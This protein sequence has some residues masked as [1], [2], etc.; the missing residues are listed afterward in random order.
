M[1]T[2][3]RFSQVPY[4]GPPGS[5]ELVLVRHGASADAVEGEDFE[6]LDGHGD[7]PLSDIGREQAE[8]VGAR[9]ARQSFDALY[10][11]NLRRTVET[12]APL[13][14]LSGLVPVVEAD[15][16]EVRLGEWEGGLFRQKVADGD[17]VAVRM[18]TEERWDV[19]PGAETA[20]GF[21]GRIRRAIE[22]V[23]ASHPGQRVV[24]FSHGGAIAEVLAQATR[25]TPFAFLMSDNTAIARVVLT[26][27]RS[28]LRGFND[29]AHLE[30]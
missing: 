28:I 12:A 7:P 27:E 15:L 5:T 16:R 24:A 11:T 13:A 18:L 17:P 23:A 2:P 9:L 6:L 25:S 4:Q 19:V 22:R 8:L 1:S 21:S 20:D 10:V 14:R 3:R 30:A 26:P 29:T